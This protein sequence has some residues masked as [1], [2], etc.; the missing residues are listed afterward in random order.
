MHVKSQVTFFS[1]FTCFKLS[2]KTNYWR[3]SVN[4]E[5]VR[6]L[7]ISDWAGHNLK[8][9][10]KNCVG[11]IWTSPSLCHC[12]GL[13][14]VG[15]AAHLGQGQLADQLSSISFL[16]CFAIIN[17]I[18]AISSITLAIHYCYLIYDGNSF[19]HMKVS[20]LSNCIGSGRYMYNWATHFTCLLHLNNGNVS[21]A[22]TR[23][24]P[25]SWG[26]WQFAQL[27]ISSFGFLQ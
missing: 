5:C 13:Y 12:A 20:I 26:C 9:W 8:T 2:F 19:Y 6:Q 17:A 18:I 10:P 24:K 25:A 11:L 22:C 3:P 14:S 1:A 4:L 15:A 16:S 23:A 7:S 27:F 21:P